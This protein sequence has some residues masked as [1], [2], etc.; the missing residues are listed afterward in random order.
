MISKQLR[1]IMTKKLQKNIAYS[2]DESL[3]TAKCKPVDVTAAA[4]HKQTDTLQLPA[5]QSNKFIPETSTH[6]M[7]VLDEKFTYHCC[8]IS[9][10]KRPAK[11]SISEPIEESNDFNCRTEPIVGK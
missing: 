2:D 1:R 10:R 8:C 6:K 5:M 11:S 4:L 3:S 7:L 9:K